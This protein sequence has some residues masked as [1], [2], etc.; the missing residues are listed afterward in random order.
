MAGLIYFL[1]LE[2]FATQ[3]NL[4]LQDTGGRGRWLFIVQY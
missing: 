1:L 2:I 3:Y 4:R